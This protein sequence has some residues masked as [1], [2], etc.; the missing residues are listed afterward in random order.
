MTHAWP[1]KYKQPDS[2]SNARL[3][4]KI[5]LTFTVCGYAAYPYQ[6]AQ[7]QSAV[8]GRALHVLETSQLVRILY[9]CSVQASIRHQGALQMCVSR[10]HALM[11]MSAQMQGENHV[12]AGVCS[13]A[14]LM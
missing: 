5:A 10:L 7:Q 9:V 12:G 8:Q 1:L 4:L 14:G 11:N 6:T 3:Y 2:L 13:P